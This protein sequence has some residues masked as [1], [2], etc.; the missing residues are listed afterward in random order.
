MRIKYF[1]VLSFLIIM[2]VYS[3]ALTRDMKKDY[4]ETFEVKSGDMLYLSHGDG[5]VTISSWDKDIVDIE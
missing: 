5:N 2:L 4:H 1:S 3:I